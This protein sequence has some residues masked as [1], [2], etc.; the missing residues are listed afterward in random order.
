M[1]QSPRSDSRIQRPEDR[2]PPADPL[3]RALA[4]DAHDR[5]VI[6]EEQAMSR[7]KFWFLAYG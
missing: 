3:A 5:V 4:K 7:A 6:V 1:A 2:F